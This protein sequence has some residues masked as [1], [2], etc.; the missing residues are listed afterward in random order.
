MTDEAKERRIQ[1]VKLADALNAIEGVPVSEYTKMLSH[2]WANG[3]LTC[4]QMKEALLASH[5]RLAAQEHS[6]HETMFSQE[7]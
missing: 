4:E 6:A 7:Q 2:C 3:D 1:A 5:C